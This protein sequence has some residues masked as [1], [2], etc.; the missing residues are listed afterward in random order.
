MKS[1]HSFQ[2]S[3]ESICGAKSENVSKVIGLSLISSKDYKPRIAISLRKDNN[4]HKPQNK[5]GLHYDNNTNFKYNNYL[6]AI[7]KVVTVIDPQFKNNSSTKPSILT[8]NE[9]DNSKDISTKNINEHS[10]QPIFTLGGNDNNNNTSHITKLNSI[11]SKQ[12]SSFSNFANQSNVS[13][14]KKQFPKVKTKSAYINPFTIHTKQSSNFITSAESSN[15]MSKFSKKKSLI[16]INDLYAQSL[17]AKLTSH[18]SS[19]YKFKSRTFLLNK[20][21]NDNNT[22]TSVS[23]V[24]NK[25]YTVIII[26]NTSAQPKSFSFPNTNKLTITPFGLPESLR[27]A[28]DSFV[29][30]G[31]NESDKVNDCVLD[32]NDFIYNIKV[33]TKTLFAFSYDSN[34]STYFIQPLKD[35]N[36]NTRFIWIKVNDNDTSYF[37]SEKVIKLGTNYIHLIPEGEDKTLLT[38]LIF[39]NADNS[40]QLKEPRR[41]VFSGLTAKLSITFGYGRD[42]T[43]RLKHKTEVAK[44]HCEIQYDKDKGLWLLKNRYMECKGENLLHNYGIVRRYHNNNINTV[45]YQ[46]WIALDSKMVVNRKFYLKI[47]LNECKVSLSRC[48]T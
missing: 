29:F 34:C 16:S 5:Y 47:G 21:L 46:T 25:E 18:L 35:K 42:T 6:N 39:D 10:M 3:N 27:K 17:E 31:Y 43:C 36:K 12:S 32:G 19:V 9:H 30:F 40:F 8:L 14:F 37:I 20:T 15:I 28:N 23:H 7:N 33:L 45:K 1:F 2:I 13:S 44:M 24:D 22:D 4:K 26:E 38:V 41:F 48:N 11:H